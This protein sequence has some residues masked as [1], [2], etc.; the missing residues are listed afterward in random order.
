MDHHTASSQNANVVRQRITELI[1]ANTSTFAHQG[2]VVEGWR[3]YRGRRLG[4]YFRLAF[5][6]D[7]RQK[8]I[9]L[10][11]DKTLADDIR[12]RLT[13]LQEVRRKQQALSH[14]RAL[15]KKSLAN[16][17][18]RLQA[19]LAEVGLYLKGNEIRGIRNLNRRRAHP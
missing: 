13:A 17:R 3:D 9:Y 18:Q 2:S 11:A 6:V 5:R 7:G 12:K 16:H 19:E 15:I 1:A 4:P 8:S 10:G 14:L